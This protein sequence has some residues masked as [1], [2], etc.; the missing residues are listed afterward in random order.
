MA[1]GLP[2]AMIEAMAR[3][4]ACIGSRVGGIPE[5]LPPEGIVPA[6]DARALAQRIAELIS[7]PCKLIQM[8]KSNYETAKE[9]ETSVLHQ[10]RLEFY[11]YVRRLTAEV[12]PRVAK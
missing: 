11:K 5:L 10:R 3:G 2:R 7:D 1:E 8:A 6:K 4:L 9:Y 12:M